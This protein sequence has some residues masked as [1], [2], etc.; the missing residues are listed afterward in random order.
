MAIAEDTL[1][2]GLAAALRR[3]PGALFYRVALQVNPFD[4]LGR[5]GRPT[6]YS[7]EAA[8]NAAMV[9][10]C[11]E[12]GIKAIAVADHY[13]IRTSAG[14]MA[15]AREVGIVAF[16]GFEAVT[17]DGVHL[18][19]LFDPAR[20][21]DEIERII[22]Q[23]GVHNVQVTSPV[24][25]LDA[26]ELLAK[27]RDWRAVVVAVHV[28]SVR[29]G[30]LR[31][32]SGQS[33]VRVW[34]SPD[35]Q[36]ITIPGAVADLPQKDRVIIQRQGE[37]QR[38]Y[39]IAVLNAR[40]VCTPQDLGESGAWT[41]IKMTD[42]TI[43]GLRQA[44]LDPG[45]RIR[46]QSDP[47]TEE[48]SE[49]VA[50]SWQGGFLDGVG[51]HFND[52]LNVLIGGRG[53]GKSTVIESLRYVLGLE[54]RGEEARRLHD[55]ITKNVLK[56]GT[57]VSL[58]ACTRK[59][60]ESWYVIERTVTNPPIV[61]NTDGDVLNVQPLEILPGT[62]IFGQREIS[63]LTRSPERLTRLLD[64][65]VE[66][67]DLYSSRKAAVRRELTRARHEI[68]QAQADLADAHERLAAL[69]GLEDTLKRYRAV[70]VEERLQDQSLLVREEH[71]LEIATDRL[72]TAREILGTFER[73][74]VIDR[75]FV[76]ESSVSDLPAEVL[77][78]KLNPAFA[79]FNNAVAAAAQ[80]LRVQLDE[81][82]RVLDE[83]RSRWRTRQ[84]QVMAA[85]GEILRELQQDHVDGDEFIRLR[86]RIEELQPLRDQDQLVQLSVNQLEQRRRNLLAEWN[87]LR[88]GEYQALQRA[89]RKVS[90]ALE[91]KIRVTVEFS[92]DRKPLADFLRKR[93][94]GRFG[95]A[96]DTLTHEPGLSLG[97]LVATVRNGRDALVKR[98]KLSPAQ[99]DKLANTS[100][101]ILMELED[102][103][104]PPTTEIELNIA[105]DGQPPLWRPLDALSTGQRATAVLF[106]LLHGSNAP[107]VIDQ[108]EDDLDNRFIAEG[109]VPRMREEKRRR[110]FLFSTH[111]A[112]IPV[113]GDAELILGLQASAEGG[114]PGHAE[115]PDR[116]VGS[117]ESES[118][119]ELVEE[120]L[121]GGREAFEMRR[122]IYGF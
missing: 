62:E 38:D 51:I 95:E 36:A 25:D 24:G 53:T 84:A 16:P 14:L 13:R 44:T 21:L 48:H 5:N 80:A 2:T 73:D 43:A 68:V 103:D 105:A 19:C 54:P 7:D 93:I 116:Y 113:L 114:D 30:L 89:A 64:R 117:I 29:G 121:E 66:Q 122:R 70:G 41:W 27:A 112:N 49:F 39:P 75:A 79:A 50:L 110:Q 56:S 47:V 11:I 90:K 85:Y 92:G 83:V 40:D 67:S 107:L 111:N 17:K 65:F 78:S 87:D 37:Y 59:P 109:I 81:A 32:L 42:L 45:S 61:R 72:T 33:R 76:S 104:L 10:A 57:K 18:L 97:E 86:R 98:Y 108:P 77:L 23:C 71:L 35:L 22:G 58:L 46:L 74:L 55:G 60:G 91:G 100:T 20:P 96:I 82:E 9:D 52:N 12:Q 115:I 69:P 15:A 1:P 119:R 99:A 34:R 26:E 3:L 4:Y 102:L 88:T 28:T 101:E 6:H 63:D 106:L 8:Y 118:V 31:K 94:G 120:I